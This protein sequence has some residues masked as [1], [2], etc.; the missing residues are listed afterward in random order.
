MGTVLRFFYMCLALAGLASAPARAAPTTGEINV[1]IVDRLSL[2]K[3]APLDFGM[4]LATPT[5][6]TVTVST[7]GAR[8]SSGGVI[9]AGGTPSAAE[10]AGYGRRNQQVR[11]A[12]G[13][14]TFNLTR[15]GGTQTMRVDTL[16]LG[17]VATN[18]LT[19][20]ALGA[21]PPPRFRITSTTGLFTFTVGARLN[22]GS[23]QAPGVY[24]G[25]F[26]VTDHLPIAQPLRRRSQIANAPA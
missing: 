6:G 4:L 24:T 12:I 25:S 16:V 13:V 9:L 15:V 8:T 19:Q 17:A 11:I 10:F 2:V 21:A 7:T 14:S 3:T 23:N 22:V 26:P 18:G 20:I 5:A 1:A